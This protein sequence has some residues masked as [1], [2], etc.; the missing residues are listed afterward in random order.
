[1]DCGTESELRAVFVEIRIIS[2]LSLFNCSWLFVIHA[3]TSEIQDLSWL[4]NFRKLS[5]VA[6]FVQLVV[7]RETMMWKRVI[8]HNFRNRMGVKD[9][10]NRTKHWPW[11]TPKFKAA[12]VEEVPLTDTAWVR[13]ERYDW[14]QDRAVPEM[15]KV[16]WSLESRM[17]WSIV[18]KAADRSSR[19]NREMWLTSRASRRSFTILKRP[20]SVLWPK[21]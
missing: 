14:N 18:S 19:E 7:I 2:V 20:I 21:W 11:G 15:P 17:E 4:N 10:E 8:G 16:W 5:N 12:G 3:F 9:K 1:M 6:R 13:S